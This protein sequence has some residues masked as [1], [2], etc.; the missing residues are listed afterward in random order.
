MSCWLS[1]EKLLLE[2]GVF[3]APQYS[4]GLTAAQEPAEDYVEPTIM[5]KNLLFIS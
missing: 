5:I 2:R 3:A 4:A 1:F